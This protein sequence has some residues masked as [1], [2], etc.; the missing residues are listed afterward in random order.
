MTGDMF[1]CCDTSSSD[2]GLV[3]T[4]NQ[5]DLHETAGV[6]IALLRL[7]HHPPSPPTLEPNVEESGETQ[8]SSQLP[9]L[10]RYVPTTVIPLPLLLT[11]LY[12]LVDKYA[13]P[14]STIE[15]LNEP[16]LA[17]APAHPLQVY[18]FATLQR[19]D[20]IA[21]EASQYLMPL[22]S[23]RLDEIKNIPSIEAYHKLVRLQDLRVKALR[24]L[25]LGEDIFPHGM[26][27][28]T[29][30]VKTPSFNISNVDRLWCMSLP[31]SGYG[32]AMG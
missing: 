19:L 28:G 2:D 11:L 14:P 26:F 17:H 13:L 31:S 20:R 24:T 18:G 5:V 27:P 12:G 8:L 6:L 25:V 7:L 1:S 30:I 32:C 4:E 21:A 10:K 29:P 16:L 3:S 23:Y 22:A 15:S 9:N